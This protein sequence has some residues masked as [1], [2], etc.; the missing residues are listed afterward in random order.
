MAVRLRPVSRVIVFDTLGQYD[1]TGY[2]YI[3]QPGDL[4]MILRERL[5]SSFRVMY[6]PKEGALEKHFEAVTQIV[7]ACGSMI[8]AVDEVD[9]F[10]SASWLPEGLKDLVNYGRHRKVSCLFTSRRPAQVARELTSQC[11]EFRLFRTTEPRDLSYYSD[12]IG[13]ASE[14]LSGLEQFSYLLWRDDGSEPEVLK[15]AS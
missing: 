3:H 4:K 9:R 11:S 5:K 10:C 1:L 7:I 8:Y 13:I 2:I 6:Q 12:C 14:K 15:S